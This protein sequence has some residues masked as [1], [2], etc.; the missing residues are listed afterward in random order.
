MEVGSSGWFLMKKS[1]PCISWNMVHSVTYK[2]FPIVMAYI[3]EFVLKLKIDDYSLLLY[4]Y[5][6][7]LTVE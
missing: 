5:H 3:C 7:G 2:S 4:W 1:V 6:H